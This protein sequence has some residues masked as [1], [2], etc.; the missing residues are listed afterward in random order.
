MAEVLGETKLEKTLVVSTDRQLVLRGTAKF[1]LSSIS[2]MLFPLGLWPM[3]AEGG[4]FLGL[5]GL[6][7]TTF[8]QFANV[9]DIFG[10]AQFEK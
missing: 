5:K 7:C 3:S 6:T 2:K 8:N 9:S 1:N 4:G 10:P